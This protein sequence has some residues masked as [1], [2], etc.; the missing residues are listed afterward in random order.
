MWIVS[1]FKNYKN[2]KTA[3]DVRIFVVDDDPF[4]TAYFKQIL[5]GI[6]YTNVTSFISGK[7]CLDRLHLN[8]EIIFLDYQMKGMDGLEVLKEVKRY[9]PG[10]Y[11]VF[12]TGLEDLSVALKSLSCGS[13]DF[14]LKK[15]ITKEGVSNII[16][17]ILVEQQRKDLSQNGNSFS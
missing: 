1:V 6:G 10:I 17:R 3:F 9:F 12:T 15:N 16:H 14:L 2:M 5:F 11:V 8:P 13:F 4:I 7:D